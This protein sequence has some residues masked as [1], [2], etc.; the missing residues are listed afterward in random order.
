[1]Q[2]RAV[3]PCDVVDDRAARGCEGGPRFLVEAFAL[4]RGEEAFREGVVPAL[5]GA[6]DREPDGEIA[7]EP[8]VVAAGVLTALSEWK[9]TSASGLRAATALVSASATSSVRR[10][11]AIANPTTRRLAMSI[12][13][14]R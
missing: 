13:V 1:V 12:T 4:E 10:W 9:I 6:P 8:G 14:A 5:T 2:P 7:G 3:E 11:S